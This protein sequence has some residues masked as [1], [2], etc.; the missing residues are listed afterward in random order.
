ML[1]QFQ[2]HIK[3]ERLFSK[4]DKLLLAVSGGVDSRVLCHLLHLCGYDFAIA[5]CNFQ[6]RNEESDADEAFVKQLA[7]TYQKP[8]FVNR[9]DTKTYT[10][11]HK[12][13]TQVAA[14]ELRYQWFTQLIKAGKATVLLTAHHAND[15][16]ETLLMNF[17]KGTGIKG[18]QGIL[19]KTQN[20]ITI[21]RPLLFAKKEDLLNYAK[22]NHLSFRE[23][24]SNASEAYTRNY[25]RNT[26]LPGLQ[27]LYPD[28]ESNLLHNIHRFKDLGILYNMQIE[29]LKKKF[30][31]INNDEVQIPVLKLLKTPAM[32]TVLYEIIKDYGFTSQQVPEV[33]KL[34]DA[35]SG[36]YIFNESYRILK[37][38]N[39]LIISKPA[40]T[41][42]VFVIDES[43]K[44]LHFESN[45]LHISVQEAQ[46]KPDPSTRVAYLDKKNITF[47]LLLRKWRPGDYF[48]PLG[49]P[50]KKKLSRFFIDQKLSLL[51]K[52]N[53]WVLES[54]KKIIWVVGLRIDDRFK[55]TNATKQVLRLKLESH[56]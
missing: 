54:G 26:I 40:I 3:M 29:G 20:E 41:T 14:R 38:R 25:F 35:D 44:E 55:I 24:S 39:T 23:D 45:V 36:K 30:I 53:T 47:P 43:D 22:A 2:Q 32:P 33:I 18:L 52:E 6:L 19:P 17:F 46:E 10:A 13:S 56:S 50:K 42:S 9:F 37:N 28:V 15:N 12:V 11:T 16:I 49:M 4:K 21:V 27:K 5:H 34:L 8:F 1:Q 7:A 48:Y 51:Q 31:T